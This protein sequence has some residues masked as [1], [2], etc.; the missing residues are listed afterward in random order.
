MINVLAGNIRPF[1]YE[2]YKL[3]KV[4][5]LFHSQTNQQIENKVGKERSLLTFF[6]NPFFFG[7]YDC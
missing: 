2:G 4:R 7:A 6:L 1:C 3:F 5:Y